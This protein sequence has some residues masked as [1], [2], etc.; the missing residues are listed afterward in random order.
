MQ[1][2]VDKN[3]DAHQLY[4]EMIK[5]RSRLSTIADETNALN[6][7][8]PQLQGQFDLVRGQLSE[9]LQRTK[10]VTLTLGQPWHW[11]YALSG[12]P[13]PDQRY[14]FS[15]KHGEHYDASLNY[16]LTKKNRNSI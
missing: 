4:P 8:L 7:A 14:D 3:K 1:A 13:R 2:E 6:S 12:R 5:F 16:L 11:N 15:V 10:S 9:H